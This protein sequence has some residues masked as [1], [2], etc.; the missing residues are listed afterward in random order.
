MWTSF[1]M[2]KK[3]KNREKRKLFI[4]ERDVFVDDFLLKLILISLEEKEEKE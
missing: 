3:Y 4:Q 2:L 1:E